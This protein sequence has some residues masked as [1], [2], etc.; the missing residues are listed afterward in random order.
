MRPP[1]FPPRTPTLPT[2]TSQGRRR[3]PGEVYQ[4]Q[5]GLGERNMERRRTVF[6]NTLSC[7]LGVGSREHQRSRRN[8][9]NSRWTSR[10]RR[11]WTQ[12]GSCF[13]KDEEVQERDSTRMRRSKNVILQGGLSGDFK[14]VCKRSIW[15]GQ[16]APGS[17]HW[18]PSPSA[19]PHTCTEHQP[20]GRIS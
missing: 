14:E 3:R 7:G 13:W 2:P 20:N 4:G 17:P 15:D 11:E 19:H 8:G 5:E 12:K 1:L 6:I 16:K 10:R 9:V 18:G